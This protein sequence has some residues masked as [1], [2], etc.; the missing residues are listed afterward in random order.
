MSDGGDGDGRLAA[1]LQKAGLEKHAAVFADN[2]ITLEDLPH[3]TD[4]DLDRLGLPIGPRRRLAVAIEAL[5]APKSAAP[6]A[7]SAPDTAAVQPVGERRQLTVMF[8]DLVGSTALAA[9]LDPEELRDLIQKYRKACGDVVTRYDGHVAQYLGDGLMVYFGWPAAHED[10]AERGVRAALEMVQAVKTIRAAR[11]LAVRIGLATGAVVVG[12]ASEGG[13]TEARL[14]VGEAPNLAARLQALAGTDEVVIGPSTRRLVRNAFALSDLGEHRLKGFA[15]PVSVFRVDGVR[16]TGGRFDAAQAGG[17]LAGMIG[18]EEE[19]TLLHD[20]WRR[21]KDGEGQVVCVGGEA[22]IGKS[23]LSHGLRERIVEPHA[24]LRY[25]CSPYHLHS[26]LYPF[27]EQ[28][29]T[30]AGFA[31]DDTPA[32][33]LAKLEASLVGTP[34]QVAAAAPFLAALLSLP[35]DGY[36]PIQLPPQKRKERTLEALAAQVVGRARTEPVLVVFEDLHWLD[37]TSQELLDALVPRIRDLPVMV[38]ATHRPEYAVPWSGQSH[39]STI[40]LSRLERGS[41]AAIVAGVTGGRELP[42][43]VLAHIVSHTDGVPLF[44]EELTKSVLESGL[45][46]LKDGRWTLDAPLPTLAVPTSLK[47]SLAARLDRL[48]AVKEIAQLGACIGREFPHDLLAAVSSFRGGDLDAGLARLLESGL[49]T[50]RGEAP[51]AVYTF[52]HALVQDAAYDLLLKSRRQ[53]LH[54]QLAHALETTFAAQVT[55]RPERVAHHHTQAGNVDSAIPL[56][57]QAGTLAIARVALQ[58]AVAH[59]SAALRLIGQV[60]PSGDRDALELSIREQLNA[61][62]AGL[63]GWAAQEIGV[64][65]EAILRLA[66]GRGNAQQHILG[67]WWMWTN[68]ITQ[69][70]IADSQP[71]ADEL[72]AACAAADD[73]DLRLFGPAAAM[74]S[75]FFLADLPKA[76]AHADRVL[77]LYDA[78]RA[79]RWIRLTGHDLRNFVEVYSHQWIWM[80]GRPDTALEVSRGAEAHARKVGHAFNLVW[81]LTFGSYAWAYRREAEPLRKRVEDLDRM[82]RD[83]GIAFMYQVSIPQLAAFEK[84]HSGRVREAAADLRRTIDAWTGVGGRV[85]VP[86]LKSALAQATAMQGDLAGAAGLIEEC[87]EQIERP[88]YQERIWL[89]EILR[90]KGWVLSRQGRTAEGEAQLRA[91]VDTARRHGTKSWELRAAT[92]LAELLRDRGDAAGAR[93]VLEPVCAWFTEG[94]GTKDVTEARSLLASL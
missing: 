58:E 50:R 85:R 42:P 10:N 88:A 59:L 5:R 70:R 90:L 21:A 76:R 37:P 46:S 28:C 12:D 9:E 22:G 55:G 52:K 7:P 87:L 31:R 3:L 65:T 18:R 91:A 66:R 94:A 92:T 86:F 49:I 61:A 60:P 34:A 78:S 16:R 33:R 35:T 64:N 48:G 73:P 62:H 77:S 51:D 32:Q 84:L 40:G 74:V 30:A 68:T 19:I 38:L 25:Q 67:L 29:E 83:Q 20:R 36:P 80:E 43:E 71:Y 44:V 57:R 75:N 24:E 93:E 82:A 41:V 47:D 2:E 15:D 81:S 79:E 13:T 26:A 69:G 8:C 17:D 54:A 11:P 53:Q 23:R 6:A 89:P 4:A 56:W 39:V 14:A 1:W 63:R 45:L 72:L 27:V